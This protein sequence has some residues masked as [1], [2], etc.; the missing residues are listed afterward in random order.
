MQNERTGFLRRLGG[1]LLAG[2]LGGLSCSGKGP[3]VEMSTTPAVATVRLVRGTGQAE[4]KGAKAAGVRDGDRLGPG[5]RV[6][7]VGGQ[8]WLVH[9][10]GFRALLDRDARVEVLPE[11][12]ALVAGRVWVEAAEGFRAHLRTGALQVESLGGAFELVHEAGRAWAHA[13]RGDLSVA[14]AGR[15]LAVEP[16]D[17]ALLREGRLV[18]EPVAF[19][20]DWTGGL[21]GAGRDPGGRVLAELGARR[22]GEVGRARFPLALRRLEVKTAVFGEFAVVRVEQHFFNPSSERLEGL[23]RI[24]LPE[25]AML[26]AFAVDRDGKLVYGY[27]RERE[28]A[29]TEYQ[30][31]VYEGSEENPALLEWDAPGSFRARIYPIDPGSTRKIV[32]VYTQW[33]ERHGKDLRWRLPL[34]ALGAAGVRIGSLNVQVGIAKGAA[35][36][37]GCSAGCQVSNGRVVFRRTDYLPPADFLVTLRPKVHA[38]LFVQKEASKEGR[39]FLARLPVGGAP[40]RPAGLKLLVL[41]DVSGA[42]DKGHL[43]LARTVVESFLRHL[44]PE[45]RIRV[46]G[47]ALGL[48]PVGA[49]EFV[50][51][52]SEHVSRILEALGRLRPSGATDLGTVFVEAATA[53]GNS[54][55]G[56]IVYIGDAA[57]TVGELDLKAL[58][59]RLA[60]LPVP[61]RFYGVALGQRAHLDMLQGLAGGAGLAL[62]VTNPAEAGRAALR[63]LS[64]AARPAAFRVTVDLG[65]GADRVFPRRPVDVLADRPLE[66]L[67]RIRGKGPSVAVIRGFAGGKP[68]ERKVRLKRVDLREAGDLRLRWAA[69][70]LAQLLASGAGREELV[71]LGVRFG[72]VTPYTSFYVPSATDLARGEGVEESRAARRRAE[73]FERLLGRPMAEVKKGKGTRSGLGGARVQAKGK[74]LEEAKEAEEKAVPKVVRGDDRVRGRGFGAGRPAAPPPKRRAP[75]RGRLIGRS[76]RPR[77]EALS[78]NPLVGLGGGGGPP[79]APGRGA[80]GATGARRSVRGRRAKRYPKVRRP[81]RKRRPERRTIGLGG[82]SV[83]VVGLAAPDRELP[84]FSRR[85]WRGRGRLVVSRCLLCISVPPHTPWSCSAASEKSLAYRRVLWRERLARVQGVDGVLEIW[86]DARMHCELPDWESR[87]TLLVLMLQRLRTVRKMVR[88]ALAFRRLRGTF[89]FL[90]FAILAR[91]R[92]AAELRLVMSQLGLG[93]ASRQE[94][95][96]KVLARLR[97]PADKVA[98]LQRFLEAY[99]NDWRLRAMLVGLLEDLGRWREAADM[100]SLVE[101]NPYADPEFRVLLADLLV[102]H[103]REE[104]ARRILSELVE[105]RP[106]DPALRRRLGDL[107]RAYGWFQEAYRE[108]AT[109]AAFRPADGS[110]KLLMA[111]AAAGAGRANE[112]IRLEREVAATAAPGSAVGPAR[113]AILRLSLRLAR[114]R[115]RARKEEDTAKLARILDVTR[116]SG[117]LRWARPIR[118]YL[119]WEHPYADT[120]LLVGVGGYAPARAPLLGTAFG[121][122]AFEDNHPDRETYRI[123]V[124]RPPGA[125]ARKVSAELVVLWHE[126]TPK[127][128]LWSRRL[129]FD[130]KHRAYGFEVRGGSVQEV[131]P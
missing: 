39:Y 34:R 130:P 103:G 47:A 74:A 46:A 79:S 115:A 72:L 121:L 50:T 90:R 5:R 127:E 45:D 106:R 9:D 112:A 10:A 63:V 32:V 70:R 68:F 88:L 21:A 96:E 17:R 120:E 71:D 11:G 126:G 85:S 78:D 4:G 3:S 80:S 86:H 29:R 15:V 101:G 111:L 20:Q 69:A 83:D 31:Q 92:N 95:V 28:R 104:E 25:G 49:K 26:Q 7:A 82:A 100:V 22:P 35:S 57:P 122:E 43:L 128:R 6:T 60:R 12:L 52:D 65:D 36:Q 23:Y 131:Q 2:L 58:R 102:R 42:T 77:A 37:V 114:L 53:L 19:W 54:P 119:V 27:V 87:R 129:V 97:R 40:A 18:A 30:A 14:A 125:R 38:D 59:E 55:G 1:V 105:F 73:A 116:R 107:Y 99:P 117:I 93:G 13:V 62:R 89:W 48:R 51:P 109:L 123:V 41:V 76:A 84:G 110:V 124:L 66:V 94:V 8:L 91:V 113:W 33:L 98:A 75:P 67:G 24:R 61:I 64:H 56:T 108:Y 44:G 16:G 81:S 118:I